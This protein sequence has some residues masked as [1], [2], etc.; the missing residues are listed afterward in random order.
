MYQV[1]AA[2]VPDA[3][4][5]YQVD[6]TQPARIGNE[7]ERFVPS[8]A[9]LVDGDDRWVA[10]TVETDAQWRS[11]CAA[12][13]REDLAASF[14]TAQE[15]VAQRETIDAAVGEWL[16]GQEPFAVM[17]RLQALGIAAG[18]VLNSRDLLLDPHLAHR[19]FRERVLHPAP[20]GVRP[21]LGRPYR[22]KVR[23]PQVHKRAPSY[24]EDNRAVLRELP[25]YTEARIEELVADRVVCDTPNAT[26]PSEAMG[27]KQL[28]Q[29]RAVC[30]VDADYREK[31]DIRPGT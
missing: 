13:Q 17:R 23:R 16:R 20:V 24:A 12:M 11:L 25:G 9:Y 30:E 21:M 10:L 27:I 7:H 31:L 2:L 26:K 1:G 3:L 22:W 29:L 4:L 5:Q 8:N 15:R 18:P 6:G 14:P 19:G 28:L